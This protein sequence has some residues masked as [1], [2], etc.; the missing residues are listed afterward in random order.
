MFFAKK[1]KEKSIE[2][3]KKAMEEAPIDE[4]DDD[5]VLN[6]D[7]RER[8]REESAAPLFVKVEK[9]REILND[10]QEMKVFVS[11]L[12]QL[13]NIIHEL[14]T[15]RSDALNILRTTTQRLEK[16]IIEIDSAL[17]RPRGLE[18]EPHG[19]AEVSHIEDSLQDLQRQLSLLRKDLQGLK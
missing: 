1:D 17:L 13:F 6:E 19:E 7:I 3:I 10:I 11:G 12:K 15:V 8:P 18:I 4:L 16:S 5:L 9:Y 2:E 14:E